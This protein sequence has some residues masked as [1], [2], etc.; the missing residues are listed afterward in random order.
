MDLARMAKGVAADPYE[1][2]LRLWGKIRERPERGKPRCPYVGDP[3]WESKLQAALGAADPSSAVPSADAS[4]TA[5][6]WPGVLQRLTDRG[7]NPG[8]ASY[9]GHN[10]GD[11]AFIR[12]IWRLARHL[13]AAKVIETGVAHGVSSRF[14]L[15]ALQRND[16]GGRLWSIDLPPQTLPEIHGQIGVAVDPDAKMAERWSYIQGSSRR[17]LPA[18]LRDT[19]P[20]DL[21]IHDSL[22]TEYNM[23]FEM[24]AVWPLLRP[25]GAMV[26]DDIDNN[27]A[28]D[29]FTKS[30]PQHQ[31]LVCEADPIRPDPLRASRQQKGLFGIVLKNG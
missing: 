12:A 17:R 25:G 29:I 30:M 24:R 27:W 31:A 19:G 6:I 11:R 16:N 15:E 5:P 9:S 1:A 7:I 28:F 4:E 8:P 18:L 26:V 21:F 20:I 10:D 2:A 22:H 23:L 3:L 13:P 14:V